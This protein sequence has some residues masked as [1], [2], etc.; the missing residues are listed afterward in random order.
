MRASLIESLA[1]RGNQ[2]R[3]VLYPKGSTVLCSQCMKPLFTLT[4]NIYSGEKVSRTVDAYRPVSVADLAGLAER[5]DVMSVAVLLRYWTPEQRQAH[6]DHI[7][8]PKT[9]DPAVCPACGLSWPRVRAVEAAEVTDHAYVWEPVTI[10]PRADVP[11][12][13][14]RA[15]A[16]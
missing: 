13:V 15:W 11:V 6:C 14:Y 8:A 12:P 9:G 10:P 4:R 1:Q 2:G 3:E 5:M 16:Q 7:Q